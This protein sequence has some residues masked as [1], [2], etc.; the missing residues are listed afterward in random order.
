MM[1]CAGGRL[2]DE[3]ASERVDMRAADRDRERVVAALREQTAEGRL[4]LEEF[5]QR[6]SAAYQA[7]TW[8]ELGEL[9]T[10]LPVD[11]RFGES[12]PASSRRPD[13][14]DRPVGVAGREVHH[15]CRHGPRHA[16]FLLAP[17]V[18]LAIVVANG[19]FG[20]IIP[21]V[22]FALLVARRFAS[23]GQGRFPHMSGRTDG[24]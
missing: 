4:T 17:M 15:R 18:V 14:T 11:V 20:A 5:D 13:T 22:V 21:L 7:K 24:R 16:P 9:T 12:R 23:G 6:M 2:G 3:M 10:D 8:G 1:G 19:H